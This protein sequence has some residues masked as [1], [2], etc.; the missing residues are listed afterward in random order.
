MIAAWLVLLAGAAASSDA[1][2]WRGDGTGMHDAA[3]APAGWSAKRNVLWSARIG[4]GNS[5]PVAAGGKVF[6]TAEPAS[7]SCVDGAS[8]ALLWTRTASFADLDPPQPDRPVRGEAGNATPTP[9]VASGLVHAAFGS[10]IVATFDASG[11]RVWIRFFDLPPPSS[12]GRGASPVVDG[13]RLILS[14]KHLAAVEAR[15]GKTL[16]QAETVPE[17]FGTPVVC[18]IGGLRAIVAPRGHVVRAADGAVLAEGLGSTQYVSPIVRGGTAYFMDETASAWRLAPSG[19]R[20]IAATRLWE[21][22][23]PG[24]R[25]ASP[26]WI[27]GAIHAVSASGTY[28]AIDAEKGEA[29]VEKELEFPPAGG[30]PGQ[31]PANIYPSVE[32][33]GKRAFVSNDI[34]DTLVLEVAG[35]EVREV[36][37]NRL[38]E[39]AAGTPAIAGNRIFL[40]GGDKLYAIGAGASNSSSGGA[41]GLR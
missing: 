7:L 16:W 1:A 35:K 29:I 40:R 38:G 13:D 32:A 41:T 18:D 31:P 27:D 5:S 28:G 14:L 9:A 22:E 8:G 19:E 30:K 3:D 39:G 12:H 26:V 33:A 2:G 25:Y 36:A 6:A 37:R 20:G 17:R 23:L 10:G 11:K 15:T 21:M 4:K 24:E 34:G